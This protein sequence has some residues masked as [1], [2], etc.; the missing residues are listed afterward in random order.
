MKDIVKEIILK[1]R[2]EGGEQAKKAAEAIGKAVSPR[3]AER[4]LK[5]IE[6]L[7]AR[8]GRTGKDLSSDAKKLNDYFRELNSQ[9]LQKTERHLDRIARLIRSQIENIEKLKKSGASAEEIKAQT[10]ALSRSI[11]RFI[12]VSS[13]A[14]AQFPTSEGRF[15]DALRMASGNAPGRMGLI[16]GGLNIAGATL[17]FAGGLAGLRREFLEQSAANRIIVA[18]EIKRQ[19]LD[20]FGG[21]MSRAVLYSDPKRAERIKED[22]EKMSGA[23]NWEVGLKSVGGTL[24]GAGGLLAAVKIGST[25]AAL[26]SGAAVG[27]AFG[28]FLGPL[29]MVGGALL[30]GAIGL[31]GAALAGQ[32]AYSGFKYFLGGGKEAA[33]TQYKQLAEEKATAETLDR[34]LYQRFASKARLRYEY[35]RQL[36]LGD[37]TALDIRS[38]FRKA[39]ITD[40]SEMAQ[41]MLGFRRF[42]ADTA[43][44]V[45]ASTAEMAKQMGMSVQSAQALM[46]NMAMVNRGGIGNAKKDLEELFSKAVSSGINDS[47]LI[48]EYQKT[49]TQL[50]QSLGARTSVADVANQMKNFLVGGGLDYRN[51]QALTPAIHAT[52]MTVRG[53][54]PLMQAKRTARILDLARSDGG[55]NMLAFRYLDEMS[56]EELAL[57][58]END[59]VLQGLGIGAEKIRAFKGA[60]AL[61]TIRQ[62]LGADVGLRLLEKTRGR[63]AS[64]TESEQRL[65][66]TALGM[67]NV[68]RERL[69]TVQSFLKSN[70][71]NIRGIGKEYEDIGMDLTFQSAGR[72]AVH[73][74]TVQSKTA[75]E[76]YRGIEGTNISART[77]IEA[78]AKGEDEQDRKIREKIEKNIKKI[79]EIYEDQF[80]QVTRQID[81]DILEGPI[82]NISAA[83]DEIANAMINAANRIDGGNRPTVRASAKTSG[84][85]E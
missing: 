70:L 81:A 10:D 26:K 17:N 13:S 83:A 73:M 16:A 42:R 45:A 36:Q 85:G 22:T 68:S 39:G 50:M 46:Q 12:D 38:R 55:V 56:N 69:E 61:D 66:A 20:V 33:R 3:D 6:T 30:G 24:L 48:E 31:G 65:L 8:L 43:P 80:S 47:G 71:Q 62:S 35:Q 78:I 51:I 77:Q 21:D 2:S 5:S 15:R 54:S 37:E 57:L 59:P 58:S 52:G 19:A 76:V 9:H 34:E 1:F 60:Q 14:P 74:D 49:V 41:L 11:D 27:G 72:G 25:L 67:Q 32:S 64:L 75:E 28:S 82:R 4:F 7:Q 44:M 18:N 63:G 29:G 84:E 23:K 53:V 79:F 40:E